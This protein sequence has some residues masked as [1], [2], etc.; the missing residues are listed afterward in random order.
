MK[1]ALSESGR[2]GQ[3]ITNRW[4]VHRFGFYLNLSPLNFDVA[5][6]LVMFADV[7]VGSRWLSLALFVSR[8]SC[9]V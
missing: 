5:N 7:L 3:V 4:R 9:L 2:K 6:V 8:F 1:V